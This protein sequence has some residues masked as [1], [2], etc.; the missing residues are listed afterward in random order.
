LGC[1]SPSCLLQP[2]NP[3][4]FAWQEVAGGAAVEETSRFERADA[5]LLVAD[6][7]GRPPARSHGRCGKRALVFER[8][9]V[10]SSGNWMSLS[11]QQVRPHLRNHSASRVV[12]GAGWRSGTVRRWPRS[13]RRA[14]CLR[15]AHCKRSFRSRM[16]IFAADQGAGPGEIGPADAQLLRRLELMHHL[17]GRLPGQLKGRTIQRFDLSDP[18]KRN[19]ACGCPRQGRLPKGSPGPLRPGPN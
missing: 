15:Q 16:A 12:F 6:R 10:E 5:G 13:W 1:N 4:Q 18:D 11:H 19:W 9:Y 8:G 3:K 7:S 14:T 2:P 17:T